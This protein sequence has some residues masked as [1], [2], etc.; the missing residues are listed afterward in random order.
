MAIALVQVVRTIRCAPKSLPC[1]G[2]CGALVD[3]CD[4][5]RQDTDTPLCESCA[6]VPSDHAEYRAYA[7]H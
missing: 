3:E 4:A 1:D 7:Y 6:A 2:G 5:I